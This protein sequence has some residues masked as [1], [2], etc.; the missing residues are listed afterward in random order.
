MTRSQPPVSVIM[1]ILNEEPYLA[2]AVGSVLAQERDFDGDLQ[3]VLAVGPSTDRTEQIAAELAAA[4]PRIT[5][6]ANP[7]GRTPDGLNAAIAGTDHDIV[8]R[9]D[10]HGQMSPGYIATAVR[11]LQETGA[12]NVGGV[13][14]ARGRTPFEEAVAAAMGSRLGLGGASFHQGG[15]AAEALTVFL[16]CFRKSWLE[17][18]GGYDSTFARAQDWEMNHRIRQQ[19]GLVW[20]TPELSVSYRPRPNLKALAR[21]YFSTGQWRRRVVA[22]HPETVS[23]RYLAAPVAVLAI[24]GG[25]VGGFA[26][27]PLWLIPAGYA[28]AVTVGGVAVGAAN[29]AGVAARMPAVLATMHLAWGA[30]FLVGTRKA[31]A[32]VAA[33]TRAA[34]GKGRISGRR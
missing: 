21:Q 29:G 14:A 11:V 24:A 3:L 2:E 19:G 32:A 4:D 27:A 17:R 9:M 6:V 1:P 20:F 7:S 34:R 28:A 8:V 25:T 12:A 16:G 30:G 22:E 33:R 5:V 15:Q 18:V 31:S 13:M 26:W 23:L 10:G